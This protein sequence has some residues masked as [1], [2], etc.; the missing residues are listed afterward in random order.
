[1][2][3]VSEHAEK[4]EKVEEFQSIHR[5]HSKYSLCMSGLEKS[6]SVLVYIYIH[7]HQLL[8]LK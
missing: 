7:L 5:D 8:H 3:L 6:F 2:G 1:M 4:T